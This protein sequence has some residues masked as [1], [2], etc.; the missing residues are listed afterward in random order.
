MSPKLFVNVWDAIE[1]TPAK[2]AEMKM[3]SELLAAIQKHLAKLDM[4]LAAV[5]K[6][7]DVPP[8]DL[9]QLLQGKISQ[10]GLDE[11]ID[12]ATKC[13]LKIEMS[14]LDPTLHDHIN[15]ES[16]RQISPTPR[17]HWNLRVI[18]FENEQEKWFS[19]HEVYYSDGKP[20]GY[21][22]PLAGLMWTQDDEPNAG[23]RWVQ[24]VQRALSEPV[25]RTI[26]FDGNT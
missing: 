22:E 24:R 10:F 14:I 15:P 6:L 16:G 13:G 4:D 19:L 3:R 8:S 7:T 26:D 1:G 18:E 25:L 5:S 23:Q 21:A 9:A 12:T 20:V 2:A 17:S 11:L